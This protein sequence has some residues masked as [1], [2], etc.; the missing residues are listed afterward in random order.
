[1][2][3]IKN[4]TDCTKIVDTVF[5]VLSMANEDKSEDKVNATI[6]SLC[7]ENGQLVALDS[8]YSYFKQ[9]DNRVFAKYSEAIKGNRN[10]VD[11][12]LKHVL[13][14]KVNLYKSCVATSGGTG[15]VSLTIKDILEEGDTLL[16][17]E[18]AWGSYK[19]MA[20]E[21][22]LNTMTYDIYN[23][24]DLLDKIKLLAARQSRV[25]VI[26]NS[27]CHNPCGQSYS[28]EKF[29][30]IIETMNN[31]DVPC[32]L[33]NDIAYIDYSYNLKDSR[34]YMRSFNNA[35]SNVLIIIA[36]SISKS[37]TSYGQRCGA[38]IILS[39]NEKDCEFVTDIFEKTCR[40]TWSNINNAAMENF[41]DII[42]NHCDEFL[43][44]KE[45]YIN[46]LKERSSLLIKEAHDVDLPVYHYDE[47]FFVTLKIDDNS[48]RD[49][50]HEKLI[51]NH[52]YT[53]KVNRG[54]RIAVCSVPTNKIRG[55]AR[56]IKNIYI[57][58][59]L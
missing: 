42:N 53:V 29:D 17:P 54:I 43:K 49:I 35:N 28:E 27:P 9:L 21:Y 45:Y 48:Q 51:E 8:Y 52:I 15:A 25:L 14:D 57:S 55:L 24:N 34:N 20:K 56:R 58:L 36:F 16:L 30:K 13:E 1:M 50:I 2:K 33:L 32:V 18:V 4:N 23:L 38:A 41:A 6:G 10:Y 22:H 5:P 11:A 37:M 46:L 40:S 59:E 44:E 19:L 39:S 31:A 26:I 47:G 3:F 7:D 12:V